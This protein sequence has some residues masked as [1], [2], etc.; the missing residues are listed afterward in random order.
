M[1]FHRDGIRFDY[2]DTWQL[3]REETDTGWTVSVQSPETAF[4]LVTLDEE[5][6]EIG[7]VAE[8]VLEALRADYPDLEADDVV[9]SFAGQPALGHDIRFFSLDL[10]N[11]CC[12]RAFCAD[13]GTVLVM[14]QANDLELDEVLPIFHAMRASLR[15]DDETTEP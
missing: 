1:Q 5:M 9:E 11:T 7:L 13:A 15:V 12:S 2:P 4:M 14:W 10:T 3:T 8:T 6:P